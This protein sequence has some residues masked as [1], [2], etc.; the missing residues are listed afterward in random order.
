MC[1]KF[2]FLGLFVIVAAGQSFAETPQMVDRHIFTP[3]SSEQ[4][5]DTLSTGPADGSD[6]LKEIQFTGVMNTINGKQAVFSETIKK[7]KNR[8]KYVVKEGESL[9]GMILKEIGPN[10][11]LMVAKENTV[12]INLYKSAK[13]RPIAPP[14]PVIPGPPATPTE[15]Q[16]QLKPENPIASQQQMLMPGTGKNGVKPNRVPAASQPLPMPA[17]DSGP[18]VLDG[19][20]VNP[21]QMPAN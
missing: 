3:E 8:I 5:Q 21:F 14:E 16:N 19:R 7:D 6:L 18:G 4:K 10:Y 11:V 1:N 17:T 13:N 9:K 15:Q 12:K 2:I 20:A